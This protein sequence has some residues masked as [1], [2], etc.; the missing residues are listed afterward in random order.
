MTD[1]GNEMGDVEASI[2][3]MDLNMIDDPEKTRKINYIKAHI[4]AN[5][6]LKDL[7]LNPRKVYNSINHDNWEDLRKEVSTFIQSELSKNKKS[8]AHV[9]KKELGAFDSKLPNNKP[10]AKPFAKLS[11]IASTII[12]PMHMGGNKSRRNIRRRRKSKKQKR[13]R[14]TRRKQ[15][16]RHRHSRRR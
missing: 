1:T 6:E 2:S 13:V 4:M 10:S 5:P 3:G 16:R 9:H 7:K 15:T 11:T 14:H 12:E 8:S